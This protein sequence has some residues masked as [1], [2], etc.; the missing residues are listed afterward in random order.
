MN[1]KKSAGS[2]K[3]PIENLVKERASEF[4]DT[5]I[6]YQL[7]SYVLQV[8]PN[9]IATMRQEWFSDILL[10]DIFLVA[11]D[12]RTVL[13]K[14]MILNELKDRNLINKGERSLYVE[15]LDQL[16]SIK[17]SA[18]PA[19]SVEH[20]MKQVLRMSES[21]KVLTACGEVIGSIRNFDLDTSKQKL[22]EVSRDAVLH[23][24][25]T[26]AMYLDSY[27]H[28][29]RILEKKEQM[30]AESEDGFSG[31]Q[32]GIYYFD[33]LTGGLMPS[34]FGVI[35]GITGVGKTA[36][37]IEFGVNAYEH[38]KN[39]MIG[40]GEMSVDELSFRIDSRLTRIPGR[41][42]RTA[43]LSDFDYERWGDTIAT[44]R[45]QKDNILF[46]TSYPRHFSTA[47]FE[48]DMLR[49]QEETGKTMD[50]ACL[51]YINILDPIKSRKHG[52]SAIDQ[53]EAVWDF[54]GF[55]SDYG[56]VGWT[57]GQVI[58]DAYDKE[59]YD[60]ADLKYAR[61]ISEAA[62]VIIGLIQTDR[63]KIENQMKLQVIKMRNSD[64]PKRP[65]RLTPRLSIMRLHEEL[66]TS[67]SL[68]DVK[69]PFVSTAK[70]AR[71]SKGRRRDPDG[72]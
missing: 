30:A 53:A 55:C 61:A 20:M 33:R 6:E 54:K 72:R 18:I 41:K 5:E 13:S 39:V 66:Q 50:V 40:S 68:A 22:L 27:E 7:I 15:A 51:D 17:A 4:R 28:R 14:T 26:S 35:A 43:S 57:A 71:K 16:F 63:D 52:N 38:G 8:N 67:K 21:R 2:G 45:A 9:S 62:P 3:K 46:L 58:D 69:G 56:L 60:S 48:R 31:V 59:L 37:L 32:T 23:D 12:I 10:Q 29:L 36:A 42:F 70:K 64:V 47:D 24:E 65:I 1:E 19:K 11:N 25:T 49:A 44:Y 34:E